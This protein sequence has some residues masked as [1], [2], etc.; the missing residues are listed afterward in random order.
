M[1]T[2]TT[3]ERR[4]QKAL[5][6]ITLNDLRSLTR[7]VAYHEAGRVVARM[8]TGQEFSHMVKVSITANKN[9]SQR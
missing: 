4:I 6:P 5:S 2:L 3:V 1:K 9:L 7:M 8:F